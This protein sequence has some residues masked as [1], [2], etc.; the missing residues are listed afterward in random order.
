MYW[1]NCEFSEKFG[2]ADKASEQDLKILR[3]ALEHK[4]V[5]VH[6][7]DYNGNLQI[8]DDGFYHI[9]EEQLKA[10]VL[11]LLELSREWIIELVYAI[12]IEESKKEKRGDAVYLNVYD[13]DDQWKT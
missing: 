12:G 1:S 9:G 8:E 11:R 2:N 7:Y 13:F 6:E 3:N 4:F 10:L 5:K